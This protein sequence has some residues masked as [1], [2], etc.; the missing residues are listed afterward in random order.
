MLHGLPLPRVWGGEDHGPFPGTPMKL[1]RS[2]LHL[3]AL[4]CAFST[5]GCSDAPA[6]GDGPN[7]LLV[8][9][10]TVRTDRL[11]AYGHE[12]GITPIL[13]ALAERGALFEEAYSPAPMTLPVHA[14]L[15]TGVLPPEHGARVNGMHELAEGVPTLAQ[16]LQAKGYRTGAFVAAFVLDSRFGLDQGFDVYDDDLEQ[17]YE[18]EVTEALSSYRPGG[19]VVDTAL[20]WLEEGERDQPFFAWV[21]LY[22]AHYPWH[23]HGED[24]ADQNAET[25]TYEGEIAYVDAQVGRLVE[26]LRTRGLEDDTVIVALADHGEGLG[27]HGEIEHAYL[28]NEEVLHVPWIVAGPGVSA[29]HRVPSLVALEDF[30]PTTLELLGLED[31]GNP[32]SLVPALRGEELD[33]RTSYAETDIPWTAFRWGPQ[34]SLTTPDWKYI[35]SPQP[36]LYDRHTDRGEL[37]NLASARKDVLAE[38]EAHLSSLEGA[39]EVRDGG[40]AEVGAEEL[41]Q[42]AALGY[43]AGSEDEV[44]ELD[45]LAD[46]K[47]RLE[48]KGLAAQLR[49]ATE[50]GSIHPDERIAMAQHLIEVSPETPSFH[51]QLGQAFVDVGAYERALPSLER[52]VEMVPTDAGAHYS[53]GDVL[54]QMGENDAAREHLEMALELAPDMAAAHVGMGNVL[55]AEGRADLAAGEY[56]EALRL[57]PGYAEAYYNLAQTFL[58]RGKPELALEKMQRALEH[59]PGWGLAHRSIARML[60]AAD[61][62]EE[63]LEHFEAASASLPGDADLHND[64]G[65]LYYRLARPEAA[66]AAFVRALEAAPKF[67]RP[68]LNLANLAF[69]FGRDQLALERYEAALELAPEQ[70][71]PCARLARF[72][73]TTGMEELHDAPRAS[74]LAE[75]AHELSGGRSPRV[76]DTLGMAYAAAGRFEEALSAAT[77]AESLAQLGGRLRLAQEIRARAAIYATGEAYRVRRTTVDREAAATGSGDSERFESGAAATSHAVDAQ[78]AS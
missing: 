77:E 62:I 64:L 5:T 57:R 28:L 73:A 54:Q 46:M 25:G 69:D 53:L 2:T 55:R 12:G 74:A 70:V 9:L 44:P 21:H 59:K 35:R 60:V 10:D 22:D 24:V 50:T 13:D 45:G 63:S 3:A 26:Y 52:V 29:G 65:E 37:C 75:R 6:A 49:R 18:Q 19:V 48:I 1:L 41:E 42:L 67:Y 76:L 39:L 27:D 56:S 33:D 61:R 68:Y 34:R 71:E 72:L 16:R 30:Q 32:R 23:P 15:M 47:E 14:S 4:A 40:V 43:A 31:P 7:L 20:D 51:A 38:L 58:D 66:H 17:A 8:T 78:P 11:G 36:E